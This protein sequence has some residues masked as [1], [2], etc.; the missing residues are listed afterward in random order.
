M[1]LYLILF[2]AVATRFE[3]GHFRSQLKRH[4]AAIILGYVVLASISF[5]ITFSIT[6]E[7]HYTFP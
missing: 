3:W 1:P 4:G 2:G 6:A 5:A 7:L